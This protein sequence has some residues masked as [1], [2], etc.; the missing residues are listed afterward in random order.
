M[1]STEF[2]AGEVLDEAGLTL[3]QMVCLC[4]VSREWVVQRVEERMLPASG[5]AADGWR[6]S[7]RAVWRARRMVA[8]ERDF[9]AVPELAALAADLMEE[10]ERMRGCLR[11]AGLE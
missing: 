3:D 1:T 4:A 7:S 10:L 2:L 9:D 8:L 11:D 5:G 6:F